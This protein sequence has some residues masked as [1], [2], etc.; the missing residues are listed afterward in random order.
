MSPNFVTFVLHA[1]DHFPQ[2]VIRVVG[3]DGP[4]VEPFY[5]SL[6]L[7]LLVA[8]WVRLNKTVSVSLR[9]LSS[10]ISV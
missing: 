7:P 2:S 8:S 3:L 10:G 5:R 6:D 4:Q 1:A 9:S